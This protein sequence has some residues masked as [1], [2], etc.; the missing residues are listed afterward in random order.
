MP[1]HLLVPFA[2]L[3]IILAGVRTASFAELAAVPSIAADTDGSNE[4]DSGKPSEQI[5]EQEENEREDLH[6]P[7]T[8]S[9]TCLFAGRIDFLAP[10]ALACKPSV[11][12]FASLIRGPPAARCE[13]SRRA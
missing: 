2:A 1:R 4:D 11:V 3:A 13:D 5:E 8:T 6:L 12:R 7:A 10:A 9:L